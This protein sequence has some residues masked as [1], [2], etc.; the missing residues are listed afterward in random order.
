[1]IEPKHIKAGALTRRHD[2]I[3]RGQWRNFR[4]Q[5]YIYALG[6]RFNFCVANLVAVSGQPS[7]T[8]C[9]ITP[10]TLAAGT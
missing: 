6:G 4:D 7:L 8:G 3:F 10:I 2:L 1:M 9:S 5:F